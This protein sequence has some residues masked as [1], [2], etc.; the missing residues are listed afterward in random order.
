MPMP[1]RPLRIVQ[2]TDLHLKSQPGSQLW[3]TDVDAGLAAVLAHIQAQQPV[4]DFM[5]ITGDLVGD[6]PDAYDRL[7]HLLEPLRLPVYCLPGNHDFPAAMAQ[8]LSR[9]WVRWQR[10][11]AT[12]TWQLVL[13]NS[14]FPGSSTGHL[15]TRELMLLDTVLVTA[16]KLHTLVC[17]HHNP[18]PIGT[19]WLDTMTVVNGEAL[20]AVLARHP[21]VR[22]VVWGHIHAQFA[23]QRGGIHLYATPATSVQLDPRCPEPRIDDKSPGYRWF[24]LY[25]DGTLNTGVE[26]IASS[27]LT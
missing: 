4:L 22:A 23:S 10:Y 25:P 9:G 18:L 15:D 11:L 20:F 19:A 12:E 26:R 14:S 3:G 7:I 5:L 13:L 8:R 1:A 24:E 17:L 2:I 16:P 6:D 27:T 21:Q